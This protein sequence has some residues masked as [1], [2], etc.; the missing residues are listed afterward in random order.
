[1]NCIYF[2]VHSLIFM[3][4]CEVTDFHGANRGGSSFYVRWGFTSSKVGVHIRH[5]ITKGVG[6]HAPLE[7]KK[8]FGKNKCI[9]CKFNT[10][11]KK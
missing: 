6:G 5:I 3:S 1:M 4:R 9:S 2:Q 11:A 10:T 7:K 8:I